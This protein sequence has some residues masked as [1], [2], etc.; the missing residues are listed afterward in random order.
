VYVALELLRG[1]A[2]DEL[3]VIGVGHSGAAAQTLALGGR[4][5]GLVLVDGLGGPW[6]EPVDIDTRQH[7]MRRRIMTT[8]GALS[9][10]APGADDPRATLFV[11][12]ADR[13][14]AV[15]RAEA[16]PVP[17]LV[18]ETPSSSTPDTDDLVEHFAEATLTRIDARDPA[19][20]AAV[21]RSW[22]A[23]V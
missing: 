6:L 4:A 16:L 2:P 14:F 12:T 22:W 23:T 3:V 8:P 18:I 13:A 7:E 9:A 1:A 19:R 20:A 15:R 10:P 21:V 11:G 17:V 5:T